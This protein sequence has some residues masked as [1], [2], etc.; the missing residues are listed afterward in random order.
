MPYTMAKMFYKD[1]PETFLVLVVKKNIKKLYFF[2]KG[3]IALI[4]YIN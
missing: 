1:I 2:N 4:S 3:L